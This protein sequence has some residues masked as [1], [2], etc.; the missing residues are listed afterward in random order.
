MVA[1]AE[2]GMLVSELKEE[3]TCALGLALSYRT[4][5]RRCHATG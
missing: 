5:V 3:F 2:N 4:E 1:G